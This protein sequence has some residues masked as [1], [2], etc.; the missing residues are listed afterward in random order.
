MKRSQATITPDCFG[1]DSKNVV[2]M[3]GENCVYFRNIDSNITMNTKIFRYIPIKYLY[4][5]IDKKQLYV[6]NRTYFS[7]LTEKFGKQKFIP[8]KNIRF[9]ISPVPSRNDK[10]YYKECKKAIDS[11]LDLCISCWSAEDYKEGEPHERFL[12]WKSYGYN[13]LSCRIGTTIGKLIQQIDI[14]CN[15]IVSDVSYKERNCSIVDRI[16][17]NK[18]K[19]YKDEREIRIALLCNNISNIILNLQNVKTLLDEII[20]SPFIDP[21]T[22]D[23]LLHS[24]KKRYTEFESIIKQSTI[25]EY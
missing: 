19:C 7:D 1:V 11:A 24:L 17:F 15:I 23:M 10:R 8:T 4:P 16:T 22:E 9:Q 18:N 14:P 25:M 5:I 13:Q 2:K 12:M 21:Y 6:S 20:I 3:D